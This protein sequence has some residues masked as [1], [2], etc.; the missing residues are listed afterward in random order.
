MFEVLSLKN[1]V[2]SLWRCLVQVYHSRG[3]IDQVLWLFR[4][5]SQTMVGI[6]VGWSELFFLGGKSLKKMNDT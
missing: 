2:V 1:A 3:S 5:S 4:E 6:A